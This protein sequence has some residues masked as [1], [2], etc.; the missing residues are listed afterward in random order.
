MDSRDDRQGPLLEH[1]QNCMDACNSVAYFA[2]EEAC[3]KR[4]VKVEHSE[5]FHNY[6]VAAAA[7]DDDDVAVALEDKNNNRNFGK[8]TSHTREDIAAF[9]GIACKDSSTGAAQSYSLDHNIARIAFGDF[10]PTCQ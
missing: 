10:A 5:S 4:E 3:V 6:V 7:A 1:S 8:G 9:G 2:I